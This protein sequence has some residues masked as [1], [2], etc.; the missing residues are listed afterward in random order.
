MVGGVVSTQAEQ[1]FVLNINADLKYVSAIA[2][3]G[4]PNGPYAGCAGNGT[5]M[6]VSGTGAATYAHEIGHREGLCHVGTNC[7]PTCGQAGNCA[8]CGDP[9]AN[10][11]MYFRLCGGNQ[12]ILRSGE[13]TTMRQAAT[14]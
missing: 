9:S 2:F 5:L 10:D 12:N 4:L 13:C 3:C 6:V 7:A 11:I 1:N 14:P 8:G